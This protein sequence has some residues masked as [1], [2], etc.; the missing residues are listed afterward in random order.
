MALGGITTENMA[1]AKELGFGGVV[2]LGDFVESFQYPFYTGLQR[3]NQ[4]FPQAA[5]G[6]RL[7]RQATSKI[8]TL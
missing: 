7:T 4:P 1:V 2:V 8:N 6:S 3:I 5:Q